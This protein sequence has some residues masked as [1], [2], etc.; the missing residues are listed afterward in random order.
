M[1]NLMMEKLMKSVQNGVA[2]PAIKIRALDQKKEGNLGRRNRSLVEVF[3][4]IQIV[5]APP[6]VMV[7]H[8]AKSQ[9]AHDAARVEDGLG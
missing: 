6:A 2:K 4:K 1:T 3:F 9:R 8:D 5:L 7:C